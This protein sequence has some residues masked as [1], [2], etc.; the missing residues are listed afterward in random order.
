MERMEIF[1]QKKD[2]E[3]LLVIGNGFDIAHGLKTSYKDFLNFIDIVE[4]W[5]HEYKRKY[6]SEPIVALTALKAF[7]QGKYLSKDEQENIESYNVNDEED[8]KIRCCS[9]FNNGELVA[10][11]NILKETKSN[12]WL[13]YFQEKLKEQSIRGERWVDFESEIAYIV[14]ILEQE[15]ETLVQ[16]THGNISSIKNF[17][18]E[19]NANKIALP[20]KKREFIKQLEGDL[21]DLKKMM[22]FYFLLV[23]RL[24]PCEPLNIVQKIKPD[25]LL[26]F[27]Y[28]HTFNRTYSTGAEKIQDNDIEFIHGEAGR[29]NLI[30]GT[31]E[32]L[33]E[34][35][36]SQ[37]VSCICFKKYF[38]RIYERTGLK[39]KDWISR[40]GNRKRVCIFG[41]SL[42]ITDRDV[43]G[44]IITHNN[45][46]SI[47][48][49]YYSEE[50]Y[51]QE[52]ENLVKVIGKD[53]L[54]QAVGERKIQFIDQRKD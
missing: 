2:T 46:K 15:N 35:R 13:N 5:N 37:D 1:V 42:D 16:H 17:L 48:I 52:I 39:Y 44:F 21:I 14:R 18:R 31:E 28:T 24:S 3:T 33:A 49:Y 43:L 51:R 45:S 53:T 25:Y 38:Q 50:H 6:P 23:D 29:N 20:E 40:A 9:E 27:N 36:S 12:L 10:W 41:H 7:A 54:I 19:H 32:T 30:L 26:S 22:E 11:N 34:K 47:E 4:A 8:Q